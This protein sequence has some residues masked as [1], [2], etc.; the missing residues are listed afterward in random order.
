MRAQLGVFCIVLSTLGLT[1][2]SAEPREV[3]LTLLPPEALGCR[4][5][6][7]TA[8]RVSPL[9]D[10]PTEVRPTISLDPAGEPVRI[11]RF[12][13][14][15]LW[16]RVEAEGRLGVA[17]PWQGGGL[18]PVSGDGSLSVPLLRLGRGC[19]L[20]DPSARV[21]DGAVALPLPDGRVIAAGGNDGG[22]QANI[23]FVR[24]GVRLSEGGRLRLFTPRTEAGGAVLQDGRVLIAGGAVSAEG[25]ALDTVEVFDVREGEESS[26]DGG[27]LLRARRAP[28]LAALADGSVLVVGGRDGEAVGDAERLTVDG[29][30]ES[31]SLGTA[32]A[33]WGAVALSLDDGSVLIVGGQDEDGPSSAIESFDGDRLERLGDL[34]ARD[35]AAW[36]ALPGARVLRVGGM[37]GDAPS[38]EVDMLLEGGQTQIALGPLLEVPESPAALSLPDGQVLVST[39]GFEGSAHAQVIDPGGTRAAIVVEPSRVST[40]LLRL[41]DGTLVEAN[42]SGMSLLRLGV[43]SPFDDPQASLFPAQPDQRAELSLDAAERWIVRGDLLLAEADGARLDLP[44]A[45]F[46][47]FRAELE[48]EGEGAILLDVDG[49][50]AHRVELDGDTLRW[51]ECEA[52]RTSPIVIERR[53]R[54]LL[55]GDVSCP[56][57]ELER[58]GLGLVLVRGSG[59][60]RMS[61]RRSGG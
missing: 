14:D 20:S 3:R 47:D 57:E 27:F 29:A 5:T 31:A 46:R 52:P 24:P 9:G 54:T 36:V 16:V 51:G 43:E 44:T 49:Q 6:E 28:A 15:T 4:A 8:L 17:E 21:A 59:I 58:I 19:A 22:A 7:V 26:L 55:L 1:G 40:R 35:G 34:P 56:L 61:V 18:A 11:E 38:H 33:R 45:R 37:D 48:V 41:E 23:V 50:P 53:G 60:R 2:C 10:F 12:P 42:A 13:T 25:G 32:V 30:V 39:R